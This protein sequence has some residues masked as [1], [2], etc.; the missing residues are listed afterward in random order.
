MWLPESTNVR[1]REQ[2]VRAVLAL[3]Y[4][5]VA[6]APSA[7]EADVAVPIEVIREGETRFA[8]CSFLYLDSVA[9]ICA[10]CIWALG[11]GRFGGL[12]FEGNTR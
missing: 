4:T 9:L 2:R 6:E 8:E 12:G 5:T 1:D 3:I 11:L 7:L 10:G